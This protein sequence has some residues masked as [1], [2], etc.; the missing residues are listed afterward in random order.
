VNKAHVIW[1]TEALVD[2][3]TIYYFLAEKSEQAAQRITENILARIEQIETLPE[4][5]AIQEILTSTGREYR[6]L[7]EGNYKIIYSYRA[8]RQVAYIETVFDTRYN[9][10]KLRV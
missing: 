9:P 4:S 7:V 3:E 2:L 5:G 6:Y 1:S 8:E 10:E